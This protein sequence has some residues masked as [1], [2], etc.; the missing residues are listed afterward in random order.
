MLDMLRLRID[1]VQGKAHHPDEKQFEQ[2]MAAHELSGDRLAG[3]GQFHAMI[4]GIAHIATVAQPLKEL[5]H[6]GT[7][8]SRASSSQWR[9]S[10]LYVV[11]VTLAGL[12]SCFIR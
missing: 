3:L 11:P 8:C 4:G 10:A 9:E 7:V 12:I 1:L 5:G 6:A 2:A